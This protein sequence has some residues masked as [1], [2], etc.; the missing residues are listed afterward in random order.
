VD[1]YASP[2]IEAGMPFTDDVMRCQR[3]PLRAADYLPAVFTP[4]QWAQLEQTYPDGVC[5]YSRPGV[6]VTPTVPWLTYESGPGGQPL[7]D[8]PKSIA[9]AAHSDAALQGAGA[10]VQSSPAAAGTPGTEAPREADVLG[11]RTTRNDASTL[12]ATGLALL[13]LAWVGA[14]FLLVGARLRHRATRPGLQ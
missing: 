4:D 5:D 9:L 12:P 8:P 1:V 10:V 3:K 11:S 7:G 2:R 6:D 13:G 14:G